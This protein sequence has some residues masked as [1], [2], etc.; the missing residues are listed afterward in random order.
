[1]DNFNPEAGQPKEQTEVLGMPT[2]ASQ[3]ANQRKWQQAEDAQ[4]IEKPGAQRENST[5]SDRPGDGKPQDSVPSAKPMPKAASVKTRPGSVEELSRDF[6]PAYMRLQ[7][8]M[9][10][11]LP[12]LL[13]W[14]VA[15]LCA[16]LVIWSVVGSLDI[17]A[18]AEGKLIPKEYLKLVQP[19]EAGVLRDLLVREGQT[20]EEGQVLLRF[21]PQVG[22][23]DERTVENELALRDLQLKRI[24]AELTGEPLQATGVYPLQ[25][26][27]QTVSQLDGNRR[28]NQD[29]MASE[30]AAL[31]KAKS[32]LRAATEVQTKLQRTEP[33]L[34]SAYERSNSLLGEGFVTQQFVEDRRKEFIERQQDMAAQQHSVKGLL[35]AVDQS[36]KKLAQITSVYRQTLSNER[37]Q[38]EMAHSKLTEDLVKQKYRGSMVEIRA[39]KRGIVKDLA[40]HTPGTVV[41]A[42][43]QLLSIVP[44][45]ELLEAEVL[46][47]NEDVAFVQMGQHVQ[48][49]LA[50]YPYTR[51]GMVQGKVVRISPDASDVS[52]SEN[53]RQRPDGKFEINS[54]YRARVALE[55]QFVRHDGKKLTVIPGLLVA[56]EIN[57]GKR[58]VI[59]YL[60]SPIRSAVNESARER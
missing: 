5:D 30:R 15:T 52:A 49:K 22:K 56:A 58:S 17:I 41:Q 47:K 11:P 53:G 59:E 60:L 28:A 44:I 14:L 48:L 19:A 33:L 13:M 27:M 54:T 6:S 42:G 10:N 50:A 26:F 12:R 45:D 32:D 21:D 39:P 9:P 37:A 36:E 38:T 51:Y 24:T 3:R 29:A 55:D 18:V 31:E 25:Y 16:L 34:R 1:M 20:V 7:K 43:A 4:I 2:Q 8:Q 23:A 40:T 46:V 57:L 35:F